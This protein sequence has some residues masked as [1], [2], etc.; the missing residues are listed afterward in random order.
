MKLPGARLST[1]L[2][3]LCCAA[4]S[5]AG[6][7]DRDSMGNESARQSLLQVDQAWAA[8]ASAGKDAAYVASFFADDGVM[9]PAGAPVVAGK[10]A[11]LAFV[12]GSF[13]APGFHIS[14]T[15]SLENVHVSADGTMGYSVSDSVTTFPGPD[16]KLVTVQGRGVS[17]WERQADG[18]WKCVYDISNSPSAD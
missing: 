4:L 16:G 18:E 3:L 17:I 7:Q 1:G 6:A 12:A 8:A 9:V 15:P 5:A 2:V 11:F 10:A 14:W 13:A